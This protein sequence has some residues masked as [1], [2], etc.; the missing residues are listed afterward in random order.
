MPYAARM[1]EKIGNVTSMGYWGTSYVYKH[2]QKFRRMLE[3]MAAVSPGLLMCL[4]PDVAVTGPEPYV[5]F[6]RER[7]MPLMLGLDTILFQ[8]GPIAKI[9]ERCRRYVLAGGKAPR[10]VIFFNDISVNTPVEH[11]HAA[12]AAVRQFGRYP[13]EDRPLESF[14]MPPMESFD[15]FRRRYEQPVSPA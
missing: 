10:L 5:E 8:E 12:I 1:N 2:P 15:S 13:V 4:D 14:Q 6:A 9:V 7:N 3:L 11:V